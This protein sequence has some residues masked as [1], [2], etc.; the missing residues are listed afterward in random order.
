MAG[1]KAQINM[2]GLKAELG[3]KSKKI[4]LP[5]IGAKAKMAVE[6]A[7][8]RLIEEF[9]SHLITQEIEA[10]SRATNMSQTLGGYGNLFS[11]IGFEQGSDPI[12]PIKNYLRRAV[13]LKKVNAQRLQFVL[14]VEL[15]SKGD[16]IALSPVPWAPGR[17]WVD[18]ME[19]G[20][21]GL[22]H[23]LL[24]D[25]PFSRSGN[26]IQATVNLRGGSFQRVPYLSPMLKSIV[27]NIRTALNL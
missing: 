16:I 21:S 20:L 9:M 27:P 25:S 3:T 6:E 11:Y 14:K 4:L 17:S 13:R 8:E 23:Y 1:K 26:A 5:R 24:T 7:K 15:P 22:G 12:A 10:G 19:R 2:R 18:A